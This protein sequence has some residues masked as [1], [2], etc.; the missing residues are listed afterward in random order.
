LC[1]VLDQDLLRIDPQTA[2]RQAL[3]AGVKFYQYRN[4]RG[5]R[6]GIY[7]TA[8]MLARIAENAQACFI[9]ND[10]ADIAAAVG[11]DG[12]HLGQD[13]L[14]IEFAR[15]LLGK[16]RLIGISTHSLEQAVT[17]EAAGADY[18]GFGP[19][20]PTTTKDAGHTQGI[21][22]IS[23]IKKAVTLPIIAI[24]GINRS[25]VQEVIRSGAEGVAVISSILS[26]ENITVA[27]GSILRSISSVGRE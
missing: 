23:T 19:I 14:P 10:H 27:A 13:D 8:L 17:A 5:P 3:D 21:L 25:N 12:V 2:M 15:K 9:V 18:I 11:A 7:E 4:K 26:A 24:G 16:D 1:L 22:S 20:Y 6:K